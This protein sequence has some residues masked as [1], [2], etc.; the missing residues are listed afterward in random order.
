MGRNYDFNVKDK[1]GRNP[2]DLALE[3]G[4]KQI[5]ELFQRF[6]GYAQV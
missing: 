4:N 1:Y 2:C 6:G 5:L 3:L